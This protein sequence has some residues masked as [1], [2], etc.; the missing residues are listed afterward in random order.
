MKPEDSRQVDDLVGGSR[1]QGD[2]VLLAEVDVEGDLLI[3]LRVQRRFLEIYRSE[4]LI[5]AA[6]HIHI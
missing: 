2:L 5:T 4:S 1:P 3:V 6:I